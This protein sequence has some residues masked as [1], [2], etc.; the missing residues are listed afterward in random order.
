MEAKHFKQ[1]TWT[2]LILQ[3]SNIFWRYKDF[4]WLYETFTRMILILIWS[5]IPEFSQVWVGLMQDFDLMALIHRVLVCM[6]CFESKFGGFLVWI[7]FLHFFP[8]FP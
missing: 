2:L 7:I 1:S 3:S 4:F 5:V 8:L 6:T